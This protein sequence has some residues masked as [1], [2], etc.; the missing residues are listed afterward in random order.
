MCDL[1]WWKYLVC[2]FFILTLVKALCLYT[3]LDSWLVCRCSHGYFVRTS[4]ICVFSFLPMYYRNRLLYRV[5]QA[6]DKAW[7]TLGKLFAECDTR[8]IELDKLYIGN[9]LFVECIM[10]GTWKRKVVMMATSD[11]YRNFAECI[12]LHSAKREPLPSAT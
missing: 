2:K 6:L 12:Q 9:G 7:K 4:D 1:W 10:S 5:P 11:G 3:C 8:Q